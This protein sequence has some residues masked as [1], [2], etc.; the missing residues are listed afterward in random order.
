MKKLF[1][2]A[3]LKEERSC[4]SQVQNITSANLLVDS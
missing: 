2:I 1:G 4:A 3:Q